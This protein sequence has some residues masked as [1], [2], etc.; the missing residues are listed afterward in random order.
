M[1]DAASGTLV[2]PRQQGSRPTGGTR[3]RRWPGLSAGSAGGLPGMSTCSTSF[4]SPRL[5]PTRTGE[6]TTDRPRPRPADHPGRPCGPG[7]CQKNSSHSRP[8]WNRVSR[9]IWAGIPEMSGG[10]MGFVLVEGG[11]LLESTYSYRPKSTYLN[12]ETVTR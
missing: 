11:H 9:A 5:G 6:T 1:R 4:Q 2:S 3:G 7:R 10:V 12:L 8:P